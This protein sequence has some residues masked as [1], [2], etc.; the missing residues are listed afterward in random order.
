MLLPN[1][2]GQRRNGS[3][4]EQIDAAHEPTFPRRLRQRMRKED[5]SWLLP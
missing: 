1:L 4:W 5:Q 3:D 2:S